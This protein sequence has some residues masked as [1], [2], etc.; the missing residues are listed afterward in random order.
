ME[1]QKDVV[2]ALGRAIRDELFL[3]LRGPLV[4]ILKLINE[5][6]QDL[7][8]TDNFRDASFTGK[9]NQVWDNVFGSF[10][11]WYQSGG[12]NYGN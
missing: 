10:N 3:N 4:D 5:P 7:I 11:K 6:L 9:L 12:R 1:Y 8:S 2:A